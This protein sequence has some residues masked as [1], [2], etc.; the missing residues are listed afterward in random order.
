MCGITGFFARDAATRGDESGAALLESMGE[1][2][3]HRGPDAHGSTCRDGVGIHSRRLAVLD[4]SP[5]GNQPQ[6]S[7]D[8]QV[9]IVFNGE[10]FNFQELRRELEASGVRFRSRSD[11]EVVL[12]GYSAWG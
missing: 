11:T 3:R 8:G 12:H 1:T 2:I 7:P 10:V 4:L 6:F 9:A 5:D